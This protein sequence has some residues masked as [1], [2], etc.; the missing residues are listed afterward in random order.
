VLILFTVSINAQTIDPLEGANRK[1]H[2]F[3]ELADRILLKPVA[4]IY[5]KACPVFIR[6]GVRNFF[7]N[8]DDIHIL[9]NDALQLK[10]SAAVSDFGRL[11]INSSVGLGGLFDPASKMGLIKHEEDFGQSMAVWG[12]G[13]GPYFVVPLL[14]P[15]TIRD[16]VGLV[17]DSVFDPVLALREIR[18]R[19]SLYALDRLHLRADLL[20]A[21]NLVIGD[22]YLF[23]RNAYLQRR[24]YVVND[25]EVEDEFDDDF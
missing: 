10:L 4:K 13:P 9:V 20:S 12:I 11:L 16:S 23:F 6:K 15:S 8:I 22:R 17:V 21:E 18:T 2:G 5:D 25:G 3:N 7:R 24:D 1:T 14:G 19:N